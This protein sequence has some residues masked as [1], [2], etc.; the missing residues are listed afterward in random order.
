[1]WVER[2]FGDGVFGNYPVPGNCARK[3]K[4]RQPRLSGPISQQTRP[5]IIASQNNRVND[6]FYV[7]KKIGDYYHLHSYS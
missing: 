2:L 7:I 6:L 5:I 4:A 1:M 3:Q